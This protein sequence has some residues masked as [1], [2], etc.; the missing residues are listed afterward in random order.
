MNGR[1]TFAFSLQSTLLN[2]IQ[3]KL[4]PSE[5][6]IRVNPQLRLGIFTQHH[7]DS[8][9]L[10]LSPL[11]NMAQRWP[12]ASEAD[13]RAHLGRYEIV[14]NDALKPMK[15]SSGSVYLFPFRL[16]SGLFIQFPHR[17]CLHRY[18]LQ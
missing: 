3:G 5:G 16:Q 10:T 1:T 8:F 11:Q 15:F 2:L 14:G 7:M 17:P 6:Y 12:L 13:L 4:T 18:S 9:D